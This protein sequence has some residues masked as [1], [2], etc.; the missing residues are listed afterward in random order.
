MESRAVSFGRPAKSR[1]LPPIS[2]ST[3]SGGASATVGVNC[4]SQV[5]TAASAAASAAG[6]RSRN[7]RSGERAS[8]AET[9]C[10]ARI[11]AAR[12][13]A[14]ALT[15]RGV[16]P[17]VATA[18]G[19]AASA[20]EAA[21]AKT[22]RGSDGRKRHAQSIMKI[23]CGA[24]LHC[25]SGTRNPHVLL[26]Y[27]PASRPL[28]PRIPVSSRR[29]STACQHSRR[30]PQIA[31]SESPISASSAARRWASFAQKNSSSCGGLT[32]VPAS[33]ACACPR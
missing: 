15:M 10:P 27:A 12:A 24:D 21:R 30:Q 6:S 4:V 29:F 16:R 13:P 3:A 23:C 18:N 11:P 32:G 8:D 20:G 25:C 19:F 14:F 5:A 1:R 22:S 31:A 7:P 9:S 26:V 28:A 33:I 17:P 2:T